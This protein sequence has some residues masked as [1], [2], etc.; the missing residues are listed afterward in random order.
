MA[1]SFIAFG[2]NSAFA[3]ARAAGQAAAI[4][5]KYSRSIDHFSRRASEK[6]VFFV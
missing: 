3:A 1:S 5:L 4:C 6:I 2:L